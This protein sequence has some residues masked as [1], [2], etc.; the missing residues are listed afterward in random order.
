MVPTM[1]ANPIVRYQRLPKARRVLLPRALL[2]VTAASL[3]VALFPFRT[4]IRLGSIRLCNRGHASSEDIVWAVETAARRMPWRI[5]CLQKGLAA[6]HMLRAAGIDAQLH[7][8][9]RH[10][11][12]ELEAHV[13]VTVDEEPVIGGG[14]ALGFAEVAKFR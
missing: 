12:G 3:A 14:E 8:G 6:Q 9:I 13:W 1:S 2:T 10:S 4:A 5:V 11:F 7:Y